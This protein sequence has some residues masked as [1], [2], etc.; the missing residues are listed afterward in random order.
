MIYCSTHVYK[1]KYTNEFCS[2]RSPSGRENTE[3][4]EGIAGEEMKFIL[5]QCTVYKCCPTNRII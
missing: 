1:D 2:T 3:N 5:N 4:G